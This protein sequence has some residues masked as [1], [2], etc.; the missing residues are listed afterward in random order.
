MSE[1]I[2]NAL[3]HAF[4]GI[5]RG[6]LAVR[7]SDQQNLAQYVVEVEDDGVGLSPSVEGGYGLDTV[8]ELT[9]LMG[10]TITHEAV[11]PSGTRPGT[12]WRLGACP[13]RFVVRQFS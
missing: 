7:F 5:E 6:M 10:G 9:R 12:K 4:R 11:H 13:H 2:N 3:K 8:T 1:L